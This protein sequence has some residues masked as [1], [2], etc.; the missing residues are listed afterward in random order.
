MSIFT[1]KRHL[2]FVRIVCCVFIWYNF[3]NAWNLSVSDHEFSHQSLGFGPIIDFIWN[4]SNYIHTNLLILIVISLINLMAIVSSIFTL[5]LKEAGR[6]WMIVFLYITIGIVISQ[7]LSE[8]TMVRWFLS[9]QD[10]SAD[11]GSVLLN[12]FMYYQP[13]LT[14]P[15]SVPVLFWIIKQF[16]SQPIKNLFQQKSA[17]E[18][19]GTP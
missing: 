18:I 8:L 16:K 11:F 6:K 12:I 17:P 13:V 7:F 10:G 3:Q 1:I 15:I 2:L 5:L 9:K 14:I 4:V 19:S